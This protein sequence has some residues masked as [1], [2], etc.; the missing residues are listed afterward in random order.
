MGLQT[1]GILRGHF[2]VVI[3]GA[4]YTG[5]T[6]AFLLAP[7][8][9]VFG[10]HVLIVKLLSPTLWAIA[11]VVAV[12]ASRRVL[13]DRWPLLAGALVWLTPGALAIVST[14]G[15]P[16]YAFGLLTVLAMLWSAWT[17]V[18][19]PLP[20]PTSAAVFGALAGLAFYTHP[21]F[22]AVAG[23]VAIVVSLRH[24]THGRGYWVPALTAAIVVN[25]PFLAWNAKHSWPSLD[26][27]PSMEST[28]TGRLEGFFT[29]L[30]PR[31]IG[32]RRQTGEWV[33]GRP[34]AV[35]IVVAVLGLAAVGAWSVTRS[36]GWRGAVLTAPLIAVWVLMA[37]LRNL[38][39]VDDGRYGVIAFPVLAIAVAAGFHAVLGPGR[40]SWVTGAAV[41]F[42]VC[43]VPFVHAEAGR[44]L[45]D[46]NRQTQVLI[47]AIEREGFDRV[48]GH[49]WAVLPIEYQ[50]GG[51]IRVAVAGKPYVVRLAD[52][53]RLV[54][55]TPAER[56]AYVFP[57]GSI[58]PTWVKL[59]VEQYRQEDVAGYVLY[60]PT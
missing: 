52:T 30:L 15:Y 54:D 58:D 45:G 32:V 17:I 35:L 56:L 33:F 1:A 57:P 28:F 44:S 24:R 27:P 14:R 9:G 20:R 10:Q 36:S 22:G 19:Q 43:S 23:P 2:P 26:Q 31:D 25:L 40:S 29:G 12:G 46:P 59:P 49:Y 50:S 3:G 4:A 39:Y 21:M 16:A 55:E 7:V 6:D 47:D 5:T 48:A 13:P 38:S 53:Q 41:W 51:R 34:L 60:F 8:I 18:D 42:V 37:G 11:S